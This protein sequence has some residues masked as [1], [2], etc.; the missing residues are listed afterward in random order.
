[1]GEWKTEKDGMTKKGKFLQTHSA[2]VVFLA[3]TEWFNIFHGKEWEKI[4]KLETQTEENNICRKRETHGGR[5]RRGETDVT[6][7]K[8]KK[9]G[10]RRVGMGE[11]RLKVENC[12]HHLLE[13]R[14]SKGQMYD[15]RSKPL[16]TKKR[17]RKNTC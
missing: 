7:G 5:G 15:Q 14:Q 3:I 10:E 8:E 9:R 12:C 17:I 4:N 16:K 2:S 1:M 13:G 6:T 11:R